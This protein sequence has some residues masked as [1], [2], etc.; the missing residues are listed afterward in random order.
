MVHAMAELVPGCDSGTT[1]L[2]LAIFNVA[3]FTHTLALV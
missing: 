3:M 2:C 1:T